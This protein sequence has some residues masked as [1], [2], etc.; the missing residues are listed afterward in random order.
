MDDIQIKEAFRYG[1]LSTLNNWRVWL[2]DDELRAIH[3][4]FDSTNTEI[5]ISLLTDKEPY[6]AEHNIDPFDESNGGWPTADWRLTCVNKSSKHGFP[7]ARE[8]LDW[9]KTESRRLFD[10]PDAVE[11]I[12]AMDDR[13]RG[14][15]F[16]AATSEEIKSMLQRF[17]RVSRPLKIRVQNWFDEIP[18]EAEL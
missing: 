12:S 1:L 7:D 9:M 16:S 11:K 10:E 18:L 8:L 4:G 2:G 3:I 5:A 13:L 15:F 14:L 6:L 17:R